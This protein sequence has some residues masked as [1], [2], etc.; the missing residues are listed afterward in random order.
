VKLRPIERAA[1]AFQQPVTAGQIRA[2]CHR[3]FGPRVQVASAVEFGLGRYNNTY[4]VDIGAAEPVILRVAPEPARQYRVERELMR[5]EHAGVPWLAPIAPLMPRTLAVDFTH[6]VIGRDYLF[7]TMLPGVPG[8]DGL[9]AYPKRLWPTFYRQL[10]GLARSINAVRGT[11]FGPVGGPTYPT[12]SQAVIGCLED[13]A[14]DLDDAGLDA[15]DVRQVA[16]AAARHRSVLDRITEPR[17]LHGDLWTV[18]VMIDPAAPEPTIT[19][20]YDCD[21]AWW[22]DPDSDWAVFLARRRPTPERAA[23]WQSY[24]PLDGSPGAPL[25]SLIYQARNVG[26]SR[27]ERHRLGHHDDVPDTYEQMR[28]V[29]A[30]LAG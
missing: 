24:G 22:G 11:R 5:N 25:R 13:T 17:L 18:N 26:G 28:E 3:A 9:P 1:D 16:A 2:M 23:F 8:P 7:Q 15:D 19:G 29:L 20:V 10:G 27:L 4:R 30:R 14:A 21:R 12:W 6:E